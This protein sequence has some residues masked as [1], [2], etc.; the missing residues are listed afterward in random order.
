MSF[1]SL[2]F[3]VFL[4]VVY[5]IYWRLRRKSQNWLL[6]CA[7]YVFYG[8]WDWR[9][10]GLIVFSS[11]VDFGVGRALHVA[12][13][14][15]RR[16]LL[17]ALSLTTNLGLLG[18]FKY[19]GFFVASAAALLAQLGLEPN[20]PALEIV[21]PVGIS[22]YT[23]Q[24]LSYTIDIYRGRVEPTRDPVA[25]FAFVSFFP[26]LVAG[27]IERASN[28]LPQF[29]EERS[30]NEELAKDGL[31]Q[32]LF[33]AFKKIVVADSLAVFVNAAFLA[34]DASG[35]RLLLATYFFAIQ[36]YCDFSGY[37]DI[38][39]GCA[40][41]F[42]FDLKTNF[43]FPYFSRNL[44]EFWQRWHIS[45]STWF[46]DYVYI[47]LGGSRHGVARAAAASV[48]TFVVSGLWHGAN[49]TFV[50]WGLIHGLIF[51]PLLLMKARGAEFASARTHAGLRE[52]PQILFTFHVVLLAWVFFRAQSLTHAGVVLERVFT[53]TDL[54]QL[55]R[56]AL[57]LKLLVALLLVF[58]WTQRRHTHPLQ[59]LARAPA[60]LRWTTYNAL[61]LGIFYLGTFSNEPFLYFQF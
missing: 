23:F 16:R 25:F 12:E 2:T 19:F 31:R 59:A 15:R 13:G 34:P 33:G 56:L 11:L 50:V 7:S 49:W 46:R 14:Q 39:I 30:F 5:S 32:M 51:V 29:L 40:R 42:G 6:L 27:P 1:H 20:L 41:L 36:I 9:F 43:S 17:L 45:L 54:W 37:S 60:W 24:T 53:D 8:W 22:F 21:L 4:L 28:L 61:A 47:P 35:E 58:E 38:A 18:F 48:A 3:V 57:R 26:Q 10:L 52:L 44:R 55:A